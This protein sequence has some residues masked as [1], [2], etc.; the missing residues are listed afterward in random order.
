MYCDVFVSFGRNQEFEFRLHDADLRGGAEMARQW[1]DEQFIALG[2]EPA[3]PVGKTL[4]VDKILGVASALGSK[5]FANGAESAHQ[6]AR[7]TALALG[8]ETIRVD[9]AG[10]SISY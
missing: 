1:L 4:I 9:V 5:V 8:R 3:N 7:N 2:C 10:S 6:F